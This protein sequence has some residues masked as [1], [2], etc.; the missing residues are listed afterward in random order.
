MRTIEPSA[1]RRALG[2]I[3]GL[4]VC[5]AAC[6]EASGPQLQS[7]RMYR[8]GT[9]TWDDRQPVVGGQPPAGDVV[10]ELS[11]GW[12]EAF[13]DPIR[14]YRT[15]TDASGRYRIGYTVECTPGNPVYR[16]ILNSRVRCSASPGRVALGTCTSSPYP[17]CGSES[18]EL[19]RDCTYEK[20][21]CEP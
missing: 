4:C 2:I 20:A 5:L 6:Q 14:E 19:R 17:V 11:V 9:L 13:N 1:A 7:F 15:T 10:I 16:G 21:S 3:A 12:G 8:V 18:N